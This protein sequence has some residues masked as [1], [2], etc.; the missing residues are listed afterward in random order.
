MEW[1]KFIE[2]YFEMGLKHSEIKAA[3]VSF[4]GVHCPKYD[5]MT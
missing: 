4:P 3:L 1:E 5:L 2:F